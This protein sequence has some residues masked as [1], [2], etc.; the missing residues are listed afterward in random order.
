MLTVS[1][2]SLSVCVCV[3]VCVCVRVAS[4]TQV[5]TMSIISIFKF[6]QNYTFFLFSTENDCQQLSLPDEMFI[7]I[8]K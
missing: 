2:V 8:Q 6:L 4:L 3:C 1:S 5:Y 7:R